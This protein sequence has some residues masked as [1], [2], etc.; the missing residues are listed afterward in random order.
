MKI[1]NQVRSCHVI[2]S[3]AKNLYVASEILRSA[4]NDIPAL[5][6]ESSLGRITRIRFSWR[7]N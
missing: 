2:L 4:Q 6:G 3:G 7:A 1:T 5:D